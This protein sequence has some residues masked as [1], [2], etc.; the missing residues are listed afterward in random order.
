MKNNLIII[1]NGFDLYHGIPSSYKHFK[2]YIEQNN[3]PLYSKLNELFYDTDLLWSDFE[4]TLG[5]PDFERIRLD[6]ENCIDFEKSDNTQLDYHTYPFKIQENLIEIDNL[7]E[8]FSNWVNDRLEKHINLIDCQKLNLNKNDIY[9]NFNYT[10]LLEK[11]YNISNDNI[12]YIHNNVNNN[13]IIGHKNTKKVEKNC[14]INKIYNLNNQGEEAENNYLQKTL[15]PVQNII[16]KHQ[17]FFKNLNNI[18]R[19]FIL[20]HSLSEI[21]KKYFEEVA[22]Y[23]P[24]K[25]KWIASYYE[26][27]ELC[28]HKLFLYDLGID[29]KNIEVLKISSATLNEHIN[30]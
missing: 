3:K 19:I 12:L 8:S 1:G 11:L 21:D 25:S 15:K 23:V 27:Q 14:N 22:K 10:T 13:L 4:N 17:D 24:K 18:N 7:I 26:E 29:R 16:D 2:C 5:E 6:A 28:N 20:G 30:N 9:L